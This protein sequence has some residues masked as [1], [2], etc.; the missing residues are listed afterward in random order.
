MKLGAE[1]TGRVVLC[2]TN[3]CKTQTDTHMQSLQEI[4]QAAKPHNDANRLIH[5]NV[6]IIT[7]YKDN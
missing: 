6:R 3:T 2:T 1:V 4:E 5:G 7:D